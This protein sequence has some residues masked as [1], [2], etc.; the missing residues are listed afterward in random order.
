MIGGLGRVGGGWGGVVCEGGA[1]GP[2]PSLLLPHPFSKCLPRHRPSPPHCIPISSLSHPISSPP[3]PPTPPHPIHPIPSH[4]ISIPSHPHP[5]PFPS[6][7]PHP[8]PHPTP[9]HPLPPPHKAPPRCAPSRRHD[10]AEKRL[11]RSRLVALSRFEPVLRWARACD[12][13]LYQ[14]LVEILIPDVLRPI[15]SECPQRRSSPGTPR[16]SHRS[17]RPSQSLQRPQDPPPDARPPPPG[18]IASIAN[19]G[20][21]SKPTPPNPPGVPASPSVAPTPT[22]RTLPDPLRTPHFHLGSPQTPISPQPQLH[23]PPP[24]GSSPI[25]RPTTPAQL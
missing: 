1:G 25:P 2:S 12:H 4:T 9:P 22:P 11:P 7:P 6:I 3:H 19:V 16:N 8:I 21:A 15:P 13:A 23:I 10:E 20:C 5:I 17:P 24:G 14:G 18:V